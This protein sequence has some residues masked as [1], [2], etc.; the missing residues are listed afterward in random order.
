MKFH[1][2]CPPVGRTL[3]FA[4]V[5]PRLSY[6]TLTQS[7]NTQ[8][9]SKRDPVSPH[10]DG[11][12][13]IMKPLLLVR[14]HSYFPMNHHPGNEMSAGTC[15]FELHK[16]FSEQGFKIGITKNRLLP[17]IINDLKVFHDLLD[18]FNIP[19]ASQVIRLQYPLRG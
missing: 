2:A 14:A 19:M 10:H 12:N 3:V 7:A 16:I 6:R 5:P 9:T 15:G 18:S 8:Q 1:R 17:K 11:Q 13:N 4:G